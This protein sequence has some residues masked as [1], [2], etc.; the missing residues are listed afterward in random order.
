MNED[1]MT[2]SNKLIYDDRLKCGSEDVAKRTLVLPNA[3]TN[4]EDSWLDA[5]HKRQRCARPNP[6]TPLPSCTQDSCW[7]AHLTDPLTTAVFVDT[8]TLGEGAA[9]DSRV[10]DLVQNEVEAELVVQLVE[11]LVKGWGVRR[12]DVGVISL[13]R[14]QVKLI[15]RMLG[16][17][18]GSFL[19]GGDGVWEEG[20]EEEEGEEV[21]VLTADKSQGRDKECI[22][23]SM[24]RSNDQRKVRLSLNE[25]HG[26][27][28]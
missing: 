27:G 19:G 7:L 11:A 25:H 26:A 28:C 1:I 6:S 5:L 8:D 10:G 17:R 15:R 14:Q 21:E 2:L 4:G 23:V 3:P 9:Y 18:V 24:V 16:E 22:V 12:R 13:Y 20:E